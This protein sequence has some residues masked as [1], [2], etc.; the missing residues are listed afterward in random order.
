MSS[1]RTK[2]R[3]AIANEAL[4]AA[5]DKNAAQRLVAR[6]NAYAGLPED[7]KTLK[8]KAHAVRAEVIA[9]LDKYLDQ[10]V[11]KAQQ[12]GFIIHR[13]VD[14]GQARQ[15][16]L[17]IAKTRQ[18]KLIAKAKSMMSEEIELNPALEAAGIEVVETDLGEYIVQ[19]RGEHPSHII[20]PAVHLRRKDVGDTFHEKLGIPFTDDIPTLTN[21]ARARL[22]QFFLD[23]DI[24]IS[25]VN[26]AVADTG[27]ICILTNEGNGRMVT[28]LPDV[29]IALMGI[30]RLV[31]DL[32]GLAAILKMLPRSA[33]GQKITVYTQLISGPRRPGEVD[34]APE[35]HLVLIDNGRSR[36]HNSPLSETL[37]CI[38]CGA[39]INACPVF[40]EI[41]GF[42]Y[43]SKTGKYTPYPGPIGSALSPGLFGQANFGHLAQASTL[44]GACQEACPVDID[45]PTMLLRVRAGGLEIQDRLTGKSDPEGMPA[46]IAWGLR[47]FTRAS[48]NP[49][50]FTTA[51]KMAA[52]FS[53]LWSPRSQWMYLP[54][55][56]GW[57]YS[58]DFPRPNGRTFRDRWHE[59][60]MRAQGQVRGDSI[61]TVQPEA[62]VD[63]HPKK[64]R[65]DGETLADRFGS[66]LTAL[67]GVY[68]P[69]RRVELGSKVLGILEQANSR[70]LLSWEA[71][72]LPDG[73]LDELQKGGVKIVHGRTP[74]VRVGLSGVNAAIAETGTIVLT[75][76]PG[77]SL[78]TSLLP[79][80]HIAILHEVDIYQNLPQVLRLQEIQAAATVVLISG[81]SRTADIEMTLTVG[82]HGPGVL[83]V[84]CWRD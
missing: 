79:E 32:D 28:T 52:A 4:Q 84:L 22:R 82:V 37:Y 5:L 24:G 38:R 14:A 11:R 12:N 80:V 71:A 35:R 56:T 47:L 58:K 36:L 25:G 61:P 74:D 65:H 40:R 72:Y 63:H 45:L 21:V 6:Q 50:W 31:P 33:T 53:R 16:V 34:G 66:E 70:E 69:C 3:E 15:I 39:C 64:D 1:F 48:T 59:I 18:A 43:T 67:S 20:T 44:C 68:L 13:A 8:N 30:E 73:L 78:S 19:L 76:G 9:N 42:A 55:I 49:R 29:H 54:A 7:F 10:F 26:L 81:P 23:T 41:G 77:R 62:I 46:L 60:E 27:A 2:I 51:Q 75:S 17:Q 83:Y 57:G